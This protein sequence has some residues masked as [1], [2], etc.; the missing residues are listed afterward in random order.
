MRTPYSSVEGKPHF[1]SSYNGRQILVFVNHIFAQVCFASSCFPVP[2]NNHSGKLVQIEYALNA[3]KQGVT[4]IGIKSASGIVLATERK[5]NSN[6]LKNDCNNKVEMI[7]PDIAMTYSGMGPDF[8]VLVDRARKLAHTNYKRIYNEYPPVKIMVQELAMVMQESTQSGGIRPF[9]VSLLV[10]GYDQHS[11]KFQ[12][13]Q[14][15]P[16]GSYFPWK[17]TAIGKTAVSAKTFLEKRWNEDLELEDVI[18]VALLALKESVDGELTGENLDICVISDPQD[19]MLGFSGT[20]VSGP[21][22]KKLTA[23]EI[24]DRLEAL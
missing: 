17:A 7:T 14:V 22:V 12:L 4:T 20:D 8:R 24:N 6:L 9:G 16:S 2:T 13:Y 5:A 10:G 21:R 1:Y 3:V 15:D 11:E 23:E 18:H 19:H